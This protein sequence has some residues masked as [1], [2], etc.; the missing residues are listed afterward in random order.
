MVLPHTRR[1]LL[2]PIV[3]GWSVVRQS[4]QFVVYALSAQDGQ[5]LVVA[6]SPHYW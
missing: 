3:G 6:T 4:E 2:H 1:G 5:N